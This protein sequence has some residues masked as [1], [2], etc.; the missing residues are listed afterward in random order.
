MMILIRTAMYYVD[1]PYPVFLIV[2][3][4]SELFSNRLMHTINI[5]S[6][7]HV[8]LQRKLK[9]VDNIYCIYIC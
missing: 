8:C 6:P 3:D 9:N 5:N 7:T 1:F 4:E 2:G